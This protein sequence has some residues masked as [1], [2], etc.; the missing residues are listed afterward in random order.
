MSAWLIEN[1]D[2]MF[3]V[4]WIFLADYQSHYCLVSDKNDEF[5]RRREIAPV[6]C[7]WVWGGGGG[8]RGGGGEGTRGLGNDTIP[9][10][11]LRIN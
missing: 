10:N 4:V 3:S 8:R 7:V 2:V 1:F 9:S 5:W 11:A 6:K